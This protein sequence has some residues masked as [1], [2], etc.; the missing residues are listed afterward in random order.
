MKG[1]LEIGTGHFIPLLA[2]HFFE[3]SGRKDTSVGAKHIEAAISLGSCTNRGFDTRERCDIAADSKDV[4]TDFPCSS[5]SLFGI[6]SD[7]TDLS[8]GLR[9]HPGDSLPDPSAG[10]RNE[11]RTAFERCEHYAP[12]SL[13]TDYERDRVRTT[14]IPR[15]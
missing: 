4:V 8:P 13:S 11:H 6:P 14:R 9:E 12:Q 2:C 3:L 1:P 7:N 5:I 10:T 15:S